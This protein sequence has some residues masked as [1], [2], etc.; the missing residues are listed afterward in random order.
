MSTTPNRRAIIAARSIISAKRN[1][2]PPPVAFVEA[3]KIEHHPQK[4]R[5]LIDHAIEVLAAHDDAPGAAL[6]I[7]R[8]FFAEPPRP[9][10]GAEQEM[11][12]RE[13]MA[14][15]PAERWAPAAAPG[16]RDPEGKVGPVPDDGKR[17]LDEL[18]AAVDVIAGATLLNG[19]LCETT[20]G[21]GLDLRLLAA[22]CRDGQ[23]GFVNSLADQLRDAAAAAG[24]ARQKRT[25]GDL[26][27]ERAIA[28]GAGIEDLEAMKAAER[29]FEQL[30]NSGH[31]PTVGLHRFVE[32]ALQRRRSH[33]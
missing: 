13:S 6:E 10:P 1:D 11:D 17:T 21:I 27:R 14:R 31:A 33:P 2:Q 8:A 24:T 25:A 23:G 5:L 15:K 9:A 29:E 32:L 28:D 19:G 20:Q 18:K 3:I 26:M 4:R 12:P 7:A 30:I 22:R 16:Q